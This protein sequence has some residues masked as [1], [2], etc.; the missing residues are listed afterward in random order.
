MRGERGLWREGS[1]KIASP[2]CFRSSVFG[3]EVTT[4]TFLKRTLGL[5]FPFFPLSTL[6]LPGKWNK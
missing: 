4:S 6:T 5:P 1:H 3:G 2:G